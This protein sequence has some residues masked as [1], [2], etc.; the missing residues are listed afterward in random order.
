M[1]KTLSRR[2]FILAGLALGSAAHAQPSASRFVGR[3][4]GHV[5]GLGDAEIVVTA[6]RPNGQIDGAMTFPEQGRT[7]AFGDKVDIANGINHGVVRESV[8]TIETA[9]GG[10]YRLNLVEG[11]MSGEYTRGTTMKVPVTFQKVK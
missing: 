8:L 2:L 1:H 7:L 4:T 6:V 3:W 5:R 11:G 9:L 10:T